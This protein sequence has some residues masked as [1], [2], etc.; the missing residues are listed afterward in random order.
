MGRVGQTISSSFV[1][2]MEIQQLHRWDLDEQ[3][4][5]S[6][7]RSLRER[8]D[9]R[10]SAG[11]FSTACGVDVAYA[12]PAVAPG[13]VAKAVAAA[14]VLDVADGSRLAEQ[15]ARVEVGFPYLPGLLSF[16]ELPPLVA[17]L[18]GLS[19]EPD[20]IVCDGHG[21]AHPERFGLACHLGVLASVPT[22]GCAKTSFVGTYAEP[23]MERGS[24]SPVVDGGELVG[25]A[26]RTR[27]G[28]KPVFV[29]PGHRVDFDQ[30]CE[31]VLALAGRYR[32]PETTR[33]ADQLV[34]AALSEWQR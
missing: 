29:S 17:A 33:A 1:H 7:Q 34:R 31:T 21:Y 6:T 32:L 14:V 28:V 19:V 4:A 8:V 3:A 27:D 16:R 25:Y 13:S 24:R 18:H 26:L 12:E 9:L 22:I 23:E 15:V 2:G 10:P 11:P 20:V 5:R 30:A